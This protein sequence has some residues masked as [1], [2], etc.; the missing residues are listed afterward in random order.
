MVTTSRKAE[1]D[2]LPHYRVHIKANGIVIWAIDSSS[3]ITYH[4]TLFEGRVSSCEQA[5]GEPCKGWRYRH[6]CHHS[7]L[8]AQLEE[9][10]EALRATERRMQEQDQELPIDQKGTLNGSQQGF[11]L[12]K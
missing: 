4:V 5:N 9:K 12:L 11:A 8:V 3:G 2:M 10:R 1:N 7:Q 6:S